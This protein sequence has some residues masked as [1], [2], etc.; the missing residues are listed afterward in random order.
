MRRMCGAA[1]GEWKAE[2]EAER[3]RAGGREG[4]VGLVCVDSG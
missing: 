3:R 1:E 2:G 4:N